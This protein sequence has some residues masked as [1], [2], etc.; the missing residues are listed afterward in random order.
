MFAR[1]GIMTHVFLKSHLLTLLIV[2]AL[3]GFLIG[4]HRER[5]KNRDRSRMIVSVP[6][7]NSEVETNVGLVPFIKVKA[8]K[9]SA[10]RTAA[11]DRCALC[12]QH[13]APR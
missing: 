8:N 4:E 9:R 1:F 10:A 6:Y 11:P 5:F 7:E 2:R 12:L 3:G 13:H